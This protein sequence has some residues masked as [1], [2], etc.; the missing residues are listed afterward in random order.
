MS[1]VNLEIPLFA[2]ERG[3]KALETIAEC[4]QRAFPS[5]YTDPG[6]ERLQPPEPGLSIVSNE[7]VAEEQTRAMLRAKGFKPD[8]IDKLIEEADAEIN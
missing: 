1:L 2:L 3:L 4:C 7:D 5:P 8:D 6:D